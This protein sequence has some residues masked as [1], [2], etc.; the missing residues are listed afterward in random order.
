MTV[1]HPG[2][3]P[4]IIYGVFD[5]LWRN[6]WCCYHC[7]QR[8]A[9]LLSAKRDQSYGLVM[10]LLHCSISFSLLWSAVT[11]LRGARSIH[12]S[13][14]GKGAGHPGKKKPVLL[15]SWFDCSI[16]VFDLTTQYVKFQRGFQ[17]LS[18]ETTET[19][20]DLPLLFF[21]WALTTQNNPVDFHV[22]SND[23]CCYWNTDDNTIVAGLSLLPMH[24]VLMNVHVMT[25]ALIGHGYLVIASWSCRNSNYTATLNKFL[26]VLGKMF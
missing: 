19:H 8:L 13:P 16:R 23:L 18:V 17:P 15:E 1:F 14:G 25:S 21:S 3:T 5:P 7:M 20:L 12:G 2:L 26:K 22:F 9:S 24:R 10:S 4:S 11:Y 6:G